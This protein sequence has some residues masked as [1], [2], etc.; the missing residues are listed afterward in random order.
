MLLNNPVK[1]LCKE[2]E[3]VCLP[4]SHEDKDNTVIEFPCSQVMASPLDEPGCV[5]MCPSGRV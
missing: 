1:S 4:T 3:D 5:G 2:V